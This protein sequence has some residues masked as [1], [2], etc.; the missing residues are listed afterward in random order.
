MSESNYTLVYTG[1]F[2]VVQQMVNALK[3]INISPMIKDET[4][5]GRLAGFG[6]AL[7]GTGTQELYVHNDELTKADG[8]I[9]TIKNTLEKS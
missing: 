2:L 8:I 1:H 9:S 7:A 6:T 5:S 4:E 3:E